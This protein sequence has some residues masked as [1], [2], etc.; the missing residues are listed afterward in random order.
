M[1]GATRWHAPGQARLSTEA[2]AV[3]RLREALP[4][5]DRGTLTMLTMIDERPRRRLA[6][7]PTVRDR[8]P[9]VRLRVQAARL[10]LSD[11]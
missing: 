5:R 11:D 1:V 6:R 8:R 10:T 4:G 3:T 9:A 7:A 2:L